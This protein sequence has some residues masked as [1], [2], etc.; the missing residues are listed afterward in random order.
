MK[1]YTVLTIVSSHT[2][3][4]K[5]TY[6]VY[7]NSHLNN[8]D[9]KCVV[10]DHMC[11]SQLFLVPPCGHGQ[12]GFLKHCMIK[13]HLPQLTLVND[14][15]LKVHYKDSNGT[16]PIWQPLID[17]TKAEGHQQETN[18][19]TCLPTVNLSP[20][21]LLIQTPF[22]NMNKVLKSQVGTHIS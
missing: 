20:T 12:V 1:P 19:P 22:V 13:L 15:S 2:G 3:P 5:V 10:N 9:G 6:I 4:Y 16:L 11:T 14:I 17:R 18:V 21:A 8:C 7:W